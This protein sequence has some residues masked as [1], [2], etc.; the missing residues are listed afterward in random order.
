MSEGIPTVDNDFVA[1]CISEYDHA[2]IH[3]SQD[4]AAEARLRLVWALVHST[5]QKHASRGRD[6]A[7]ECLKS[8]NESYKKD[9]KFFS[10]VGCYRTKNYVQARREACSLLE[11]FP[12][13]RQAEHLKDCIDDAIV[14]EGLQGL[15]VAAAVAGVAGLVLTLAFSGGRK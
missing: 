2:F 12:D 8:A 11:E 13:F 7:A 9:Y 10:A 4:V 6:L 15:G 3:G 5:N 1:H 14:R